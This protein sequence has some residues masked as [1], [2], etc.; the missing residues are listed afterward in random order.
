MLAP[1]G[2]GTSAQALPWLPCTGW[3]HV[4]GPSGSLARAGPVALSLDPPLLPSLPFLSPPGL[5][6]IVLR[7]FA[8][9]VFP[10]SA[11]HFCLSVQTLL[12]FRAQV[13][14]CFFQEAVSD[15]L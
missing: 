4:E 15:S 9:A 6:Q 5:A 12:S 13:K 8:S 1:E 2:L 3:Q 14:S 10:L 7:E 11:S